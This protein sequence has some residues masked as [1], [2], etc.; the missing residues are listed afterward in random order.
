MKIQIMKHNDNEFIFVQMDYDQKKIDEIKSI[1]GRKWSSQKK[2]WYFPVNIE[3]VLQLKAKFSTDLQIDPNVLVRFQNLCDDNFIKNQSDLLEKKAQNINE[4]I[5][6]DFFKKVL[7]NRRY[8][9]NTIDSYCKHILKF[10]QF[11]KIKKNFNK[12]NFEKYINEEIIS[13]KYSSSYQNQAINAIKLY[14]DTY[15]LE[16]VSLSEIIRPRTEKRL[17]TV[18]SQAEIAKILS[19]LKNLKHRTIISLAYSGGLRISEV[20]ELKLKDIDASKDVIYIRGAKGKK[21]RRVGL[22]KKLKNMLK[23]YYKYYKPTFYLFEGQTGEKYSVR[24]IQQFFYKA[25]NEAGIKNNA[26]FHSLRHSYA[27]HLLEAGIDIRVIQE[28]LGHKNVKTTE[29]YTHVYLSCLH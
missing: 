22:S 16:N 17:P 20:V 18:L 28:L 6:M 8:S 9:S 26:T 12:K 21:D 25:K 11:I 10:F 3:I 29:I 5:D 4:E 7:I 15:N 23:D 24:S 13:K 2:M 27:T 14:I 19:S 1:E